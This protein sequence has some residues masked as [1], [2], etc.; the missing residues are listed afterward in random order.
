MLVR[1]AEEYLLELLRTNAD[2]VYHVRDRV[3]AVPAPPDVALPCLVCERIDTDDVQYQGGRTGLVQA[4]C[5]V[6]VWSYS[7][8]EAMQVAA[9]VRRCLAGR[10][11]V[12]GKAVAIVVDG[13]A[14]EVQVPDGS[15]VAL[16]SASVTA[17]TWYVED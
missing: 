12:L 9:A 11:I 7:Y 16:Y 13:P 15:D 2:V 14:I 5:Q 6:T 4:T 3:Y 17:R 10:H 1:S 8:S